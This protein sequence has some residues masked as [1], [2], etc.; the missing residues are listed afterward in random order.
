MKFKK[1]I[2]IILKLTA[3]VLCIS[4]E[5]IIGLPLIFTLA[6]LIWLDQAQEQVYFYPLLLLVLSYITA[7]IYNVIWPVSFL[8]WVMTGLLTT[9]SSTKI[10]TK[11]RRFFIMTIVQNLFWLWWV[12]LPVSYLTVV[13][14]VVSYLLA[15][16]W[17]RILKQKT[18]L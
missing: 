13:Q 4:M 16:M 15:I 2:T 6:G 9:F 14:F 10:K 8:V 12:Q 11:N 5:R 3:L 7:I 18:K 17:M 1:I